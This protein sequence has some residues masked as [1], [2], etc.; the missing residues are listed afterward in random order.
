MMTIGQFAGA[1]A[2]EP[3]PVATPN[4][5]RSEAKIG[6]YSISIFPSEVQAGGVAVVRA[7]SRQA[8]KQ[9][10]LISVSFES[11]E[12]E[13]FK[14][15][16]AK[17]SIKLG[18][19]LG[20]PLSQKPGEMEIKVCVSTTTQSA[21]KPC[22]TLTITVK[23]RPTASQSETLDAEEKAVTPVDPQLLEKMLAEEEEINQLYETESK[24]LYPNGTFSE[25]VKF[26]KTSP[27]GIGRVYTTNA[28]R[29]THWGIDYAAPSGT[30]VES[31]Q[32]GK[33]V[34]VGNLYFS[35]KTVI[36]DH[37]FGIF[38][39]YAHLNTNKIRRGIVVDKGQIVGHSGKT[40][41]ATGALLHWQAILHRVK[42][43]PFEL[44]RAS[45][46]LFLDK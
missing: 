4:L 24:P 38:T 23:E 36:L 21:T 17:G 42:V 32:I 25:P 6:D 12:F 10:D 9:T 33:V 45:E 27:F 16:P 20:V 26:R 37:G 34:Y 7:T 22:E 31:S 15:K 29:R 1:T 35:G 30:P 41:K 28:R 40:G 3:S 39:L 19:F 14:Y 8:L 11:V 2:T 44:V 18:G 43:D 5:N 13:L 46:Q